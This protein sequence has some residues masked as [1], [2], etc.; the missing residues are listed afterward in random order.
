MHSRRHLLL[1]PRFPIFNHQWPGGAGRVAHL[2]HGCAQH[3]RTD[4]HAP[5]HALSG[6]VH[7]LAPHSSAHLLH[8]HASP[9]SLAISHTPALAAMHSPC[10]PRRLCSPLSLCSPRSSSLLAPPSL[11][12]RGVACSLACHSSLAALRSPLLARHSSLALCAAPASKDGSCEM[13][14]G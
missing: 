6:S 9:R 5:V 3:T 12:T 11:C 4:S 8:M 13:E 7:A 14:R 10:R 1:R 2:G